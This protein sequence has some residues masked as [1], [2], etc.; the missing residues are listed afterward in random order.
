M[1]MQRAWIVP[2]LAMMALSLTTNGAL[3]QGYPGPAPGY[4]QAMMGPPPG[5]D[6]NT[7]Q[8]APPGAQYAP[9]GAGY[10][11]PQAAGYYQP[12]A[13][14]QGGPPPEG[15]PPMQTGMSPE[16]YGGAEQE[17][18]PCPQ[19]GGAGCDACGNNFRG[20]LG[21]VLGAVGPYPDGG[22]GA[23]RWCDFSLDFMYLKRDAVGKQDAVGRHQDFASTGIL[24]PIALSTS[25]MNFLWSPSFRLSCA[26]QVGAG[27]NLE[28]TYYGLFFHHASDQ[29][30]SATHNLFSV[31][32][33]YGVLPFNGFAETDLSSKQ[34]LSDSS[35]FNSFETNF[36][37]RWVSANSRYQGS[38]LGGVRYFQLNEAFEY[39]TLSPSSQFNATGGYS[40]TSVL[41]FNSLTGIQLGGD[42][43]LNLLPGF[44]VGAEFKAGVFGNHAN[45]VSTLAFSSGTPFEE[46]VK[47]NQVAF[48]TN[49]DLMATYRLNYHWTAKI[50]YHFL[51]VDGVALAAENF[52]PVPP[53]VFFPSP[54]VNRV[55]TINSSGELFYSGFTAGMEFMW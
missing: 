14:P 7:I 1:K 45:Q 47:N 53:K 29:A 11:G 10:G 26:F 51:Y 44:R 36:R 18:G 15:V 3:A 8:Y 35:R 28:F 2:V 40:N 55:A 54:L 19:C 16:G 46:K 50:G 22:A 48:V 49:A 6:P 25:N 9:P 39:A 5:Y 13:A 30:I 4:G 37:Q 27:S 33:Q 20:L 38:W 21:D 24:G 12:G 17:G 23:V 52:N 32:S 43:W 41:T 34:T 42:F 31:Y